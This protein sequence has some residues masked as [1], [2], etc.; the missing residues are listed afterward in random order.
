MDVHLPRQDYSPVKFMIKCF[1]ANYPES[2]G[3]VLIHKAPWIFSGLS[4]SLNW[5]PYVLKLCCTGIWNIIKGWLDP[6]VAAK[7]H[8]TK[9]VKDLEEFI[10]RD[11]I[12]KELEGDENWEYKYVECERD[13]NKPME[14]TATRDQLLAERRE[15]G[16]E[17]QDA[18]ISWISAS[19]KGDKDAVATAKDRRKDLIER[20]R[21]QY[22]QLDPYVRAR[23]LYDRLN[24]IQGNGKIDFYSAES[25][26]KGN[27]ASSQ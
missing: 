24:V 12:M 14:D 27:A 17:I 13:E 2:L 18:T 3:V 20:L 10:P 1:E 6:V 22:W 16:K 4:S 11:R 15:L 25:M 26:S 21:V 23:S 19:S 5:K 7:V 8:F 9:N